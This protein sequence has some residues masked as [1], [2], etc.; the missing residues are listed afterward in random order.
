MLGSDRQG[1]NFESCVWRTV[2]SRS[3]H[4]LKPHLFH[5]FFKEL[6]GLK[7][8]SS[9]LHMKHNYESSIESRA[10]HEKSRLYL[11]L[12]PVNTRRCHSHDSVLDG[13]PT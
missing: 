9:S 8:A 4:C 5:F 13:G 11:V 1:S 3:S 10:S 2:S 7:S 6:R 12:Y